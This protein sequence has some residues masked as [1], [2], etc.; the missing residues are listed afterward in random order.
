MPGGYRTAAVVEPDRPDVCGICG[1]G[2]HDLYECTKQKAEEARRYAQ[3]SKR[4]ATFAFCF[5]LVN[6]LCQMG[7]MAVKY[8][9][10]GL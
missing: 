4:F 8:H 9:W 3:K 5:S 10:W 6:F 1:G 7:L 2:P